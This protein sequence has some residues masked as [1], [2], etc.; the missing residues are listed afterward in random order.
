MFQS[1]ML[2]KTVTLKKDGNEVAFRIVGV[3]A[4]NG[5]FTLLASDVET[6]LL[7]E[8][9]VESYDVFL[10]STE[11]TVSEAQEGISEGVP[12]CKRCETP[13]VPRNGRKGRF[14]GCQNYESGCRY[15]ISIDPL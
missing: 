14:W 5:M 11:N 4:S 1:S 15:T 12:C 13:M 9:D 8:L 3:T 6:G 7:K 2:G 10:D